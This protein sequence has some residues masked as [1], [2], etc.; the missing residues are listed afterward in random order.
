M[1]VTGSNIELH[2]KHSDTDT[3]IGDGNGGSRILLVLLVVVGVVAV[4]ALVVACISITNK[5]NMTFNVDDGDEKS[6]DKEYI[7]TFAI[8]HDGT[9]LEY[10]D[11]TGGL[12][13]FHVDIVNAVCQIANKNCRLIFDL[14]QN[15]WDSEVGHFP[16]AGKGL[17]GRWYDACTGWFATYERLRSVD[18]TD[19]FRSAF[20]AAFYVKNG[21]NRNFDWTNIAGKKI[22][23]FDGWASDE[24]CIGRNSEKI[25]GT[26][27]TDPN[28]FIHYSNKL[29]ILNAINN[30][31][32]DAAFVNTNMFTQTEAEK[33]GDD[34]TC[35]RGGGAMMMRKDSTLASWWNPA[36]TRLKE[37]SEYR[38]I[39]QAVTDDH[40]D[41]PGTVVC[42]D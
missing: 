8:G 15:C 35:V 26:D 24:Y 42:V 32:V 13:G 30:E 20:P 23:I 39:C 37:T 22:A 41:M 9:S 28:Q 4:V 19:E 21:N 34:L 12:K 31:L 17:L 29:A 40:G 3:M 6:S 16:F 38:Q 36:F 11:E 10:I 7:W 1:D 27:V 14:Y 18:F 25:A 2:M 33:V 5:P